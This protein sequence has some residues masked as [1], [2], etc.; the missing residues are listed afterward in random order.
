MGSIGHCIGMC[1]GFIVAYSSAKIE[2]KSS[3]ISQIFCHLYYNLGRIT[4]Y[5]LL[6]GVFGFLGQSINFSRV[7]FG[8][9]Y[10]I[11]GILM[12]LMGLSLMGQIKFLTSIESSL[13]L[14]PKIRQLFSTLMKSKSKSSFYF[15]GVLNGFLPCGLVYFFVISAVT[16]G[17]WYYGVLIMVIFGVSTMP[18]MLGFGYLVGFLK[19]TK[20]RELMLKIAGVIII[21]Y[22]IYLSYLGF[23][24]AKS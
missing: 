11:V 23:I 22:G 17:T 20:F 16:S 4:S 13:A 14:H 7:A 9:V 10:F 12:V 21:L 6:G 15:L 8:Y 24:A 5:A 1:G 3:Q 18:A 19:G 2:P